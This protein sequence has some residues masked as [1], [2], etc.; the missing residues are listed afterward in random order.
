V[1][2][3]LA[4][5]PNATTSSIG[6]STTR[7]TGDF[8]GSFAFTGPFRTFG[9]IGAPF[10]AVVATDFGCAFRAFFAGPAACFK[11]FAN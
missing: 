5:T 11:S 6:D 2:V 4:A 3:F 8:G 7:F 10:F 9:T 1:A